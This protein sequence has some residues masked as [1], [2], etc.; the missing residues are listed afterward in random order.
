MKKIILPFFLVLLLIGCSIPDEIGL[1]SWT[2]PI[3]LV[4]LNDVFDAEFIAE[5]VGSFQTNGDTLQFYEIISESQYFGD[6]EIEDTGVRSEIYSLGEIAPDWFS[7]HNGLQVDAISGYPDITVPFEII[8]D[9][10]PFSE[11]E[12]I[13]F[14]NGDLHL[15]ITNNTVFWFGNAPDG[16]PLI[17]QVLDANDE[18]LIEEAIFENIAPLGGTA[19]EIISLADSLVSNDITLRLLGE[20]DITG[21]NTAII[22]TSTT[23]QLDIQITDIQAEYIINAMVPSQQ[24]EFI[25][26]YKEIDIV[27][28]EIVGEDSIEFRGNSSI[29]FTIES[30][31]PMIASFELIAKRDAIEI[32][33]TDD[34]GN[35]IN[36]NVEEGIS[37]IEF[38][39][40]DYNINELLQ[41]IP[42]GFEYSLDPSIGDG[43]IISYLSFDDS[44]SIDFEVIAD[45][46]ILTF[47]E[48]GIWIIPLIDGELSI[49]TQDTEVFD[50]TM[51]D[52]YNSGKIIF[53]YW[54]NTGME[55]GFDFLVS[56]DS[57]SVLT[58]I[59]NFEE[60]DTSNVQMFRIPL[61]EETSG[62]NYKE[63]ELNVLQNE[64]SYFVS[65]SVYTLPRIHIFSN[66]E[67][68][69]AG[70]LKIQADLVIEIDISHDLINE[71][72]E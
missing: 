44:I 11:F 61:F 35:P 27:Q 1:P 21:N 31:I 70:G 22:D 58:E 33:L 49:D 18:L 60:P 67:N 23:G 42:D 72:D 13:K 55:V 62:D 36:I 53:K 38:T 68:P 19:S 12:Q 57:S 54:N 43:T 16:V 65:D 4:I 66:G 64:L 41:I 71:E 34:E 50:Q 14:V 28:A 39:S 8:K 32:P 29:I 52:A 51:S 56:D 48:D 46:Q 37:Q 7:Q 5:E 63:L 10:E 30:Q 45:L 17:I 2:V 47:A 6:I 69:W 15:T 25:E 20:G 24:I 9:F 3:R 26:G 59:F 40:D